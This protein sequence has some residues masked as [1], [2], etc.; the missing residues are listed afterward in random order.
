[1]ETWMLV[2]KLHFIQREVGLIMAKLLANRSIV[3]M[4]AFGEEYNIT[5]SSSSPHMCSTSKAA[6]RAGAGSDFVAHMA[7]VNLRAE[8]KQEKRIHPIRINR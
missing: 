1:M 2:A 4:E 5:N 7:N 6:F 3:E 8:S